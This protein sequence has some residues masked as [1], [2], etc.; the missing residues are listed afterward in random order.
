MGV[1][2]HALQHAYTSTGASTSASTS[3]STSTTTTTNT[4]TSRIRTTT[5]TRIGSDGISEGYIG[6]SAGDGVVGDGGISGEGFGGGGGGTGGSLSTVLTVVSPHLTARSLST[7]LHGLTLLAANITPTPTPP[8]PSPTPSPTVMP[9][10]PESELN[11]PGQGLDIDTQGL[12][13]GLSIGTP[14]QRLG[15]NNFRKQSISPPPPVVTLPP[16]VFQALV[17]VRHTLTPQ[18]VALAVYSLGKLGYTWDQ[19][20]EMGEE[21]GE[22]DGKDEGVSEDISREGVDE[23]EGEGDDEGDGGSSSSSVVPTPR[24]TE[25]LLSTIAREA[26]R[27]NAQ[28]LGLATLTSYITSSIVLHLHPY[29]HSS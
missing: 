3:I 12:G 25:A 22:A 5:N 15:L 21:M 17:S 28:V 4:S 23:D 14:E 9:P 29:P 13:Q 26:P 20:D 11:T 10:P 6:E 8:S 2:Y 24:L 18:G 1:S 16:A 7:L 27:M 19:L